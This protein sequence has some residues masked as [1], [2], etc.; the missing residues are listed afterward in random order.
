MEVVH[1]VK[2][3]DRCLAIGQTP[4]V[5]TRGHDQLRQPI[6]TVIK[7]LKATQDK[8]IEIKVMGNHNQTGALLAF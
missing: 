2:H 6:A 7:R 8:H 4:D 5:S 3:Q 1:I